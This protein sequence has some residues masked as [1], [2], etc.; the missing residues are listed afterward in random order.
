M[1]IDAVDARGGME[2]ARLRRNQ[3]G[4]GYEDLAAGWRAVTGECEGSFDLQWIGRR[5]ASRGLRDF[6][7][8]V[9]GQPAFDF[10]GHV[11]TPAGFIVVALIIPDVAGPDS[12]EIHDQSSAGG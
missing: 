5:I 4:N 9:R 12:G 2:R 7:F 3:R 1:K 11:L 6:E 10:V 8:R